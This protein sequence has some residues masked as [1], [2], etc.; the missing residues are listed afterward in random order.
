M[1]HLEFSE[2]PGAWERHVIRKT[3]FPRLFVDKNPP[4]TRDLEHA[5]LLDQQELS[6]LELELAQLLE[7]CTTITETS[8]IEHV[9][10][11]KA[12]LDRCYDT[13][14]GLGADLSEQ[15]EALTLLNEV[16][17]TAIRRALR[18]DDEH[19]RLLLIKQESLR[20]RHL[21]RLNYPIVCDLLRSVCPIPNAEIPAAMLSE[22][23][24]SFTVALEVLD[25]NKRKYLAEGIDT[26]AARLK[27]KANTLGIERKQK[28]LQKML[29]ASISQPESHSSVE[30]EPG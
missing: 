29:T 4:V 22:S 25:E 20:M 5:Q 24:E 11:I 19:G 9:T 3:D 28:L 23:D 2:W 27:D 30:P 13:A 17:T 21:T 12:D 10:K 15:K 8:E 7:K 26:I 14:C 6:Q 16:I 1:P 18:D